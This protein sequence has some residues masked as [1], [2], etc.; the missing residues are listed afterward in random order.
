MINMANTETVLSDTK[1]PRQVIE[2][3]NLRK[4]FDDM[5]VL[6]NLSLK[7]VIGL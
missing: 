2:I 5:E 7:L 6:K 1:T 4:G 3:N